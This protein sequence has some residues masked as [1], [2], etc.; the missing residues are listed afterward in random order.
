[1]D[2]KI[3]KKDFLDALAQAQGVVERKN[4][5]PVLSNVLLDAEKQGLKISA[6]DL[7]V[8]VVRQCPAQVLQ[9]GKITVLARSL[10]DIVREVDQDEI[11]FKVDAQD[12]VEVTAGASQFKIPGLTA[13]EFPALPTIP[14][15]LS[16]IPCELVK[17][18]VEKTSFSMSTDETRYNLNGV[19][20]QG[21]KEGE[22]RM[23]ATDGHRLALVDQ[24]I[25]SGGFG[26]VKVI[27][28][29]KGVSEL[30]KM[31][32]QEGSFEL[33][34]GPKNLFA[35]KGNVSLFIR[36]ID[37]EYPDYTRVIPKENDKVASIPRGLFVGALRRVSLLSNERSHGVVLSFSP[38]H[39][40]ISTNNPDLG[41]ARE[42]LTAEYKGPNMNIGF[43]ARYFL[44]VLDVIRDEKVILELKDELSPCLIRSEYDRGFQCVIMPMRI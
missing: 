21:E 38:G 14:D 11:V 37:G 29:R 39:L 23:V 42:E 5:M 41:E 9:G 22:V 17:N 6:T 31:V 8:T 28:P 27:I 36:L 7:E 40:D 12:R 10:H 34:V 30:K 16:E 19:L 1:M 4:T 13:K 35:R 15:S 32:S 33:G 44:D 25:P 2:F 43:N 3:T 24:K 20:L 18:M 26:A